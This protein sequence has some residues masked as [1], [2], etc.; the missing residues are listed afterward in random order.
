MAPVM[1]SRA[2]P[3]GNAPEV[4][5]QLTTNVDITCNNTNEARNKGSRKH[6]NS[7]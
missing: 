1:L 7:K 5:A 4:P 6:G 3:V 2:N